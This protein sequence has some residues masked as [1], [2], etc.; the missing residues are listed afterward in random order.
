MP[1]MLAKLV[2]PRTSPPT[3][4]TR[5]QDLPAPGLKSLSR[6]S[7][8]A[9]VLL[10]G[11]PGRWTRAVS[12]GMNRSAG[13]SDAAALARTEGPLESVVLGELQS[14]G[15]W[16]LDEEGEPCEL[17]RA[18]LDG[19]RWRPVVNY[20]GLCLG[21][22]AGLSLD[23]HL[24]STPSGPVL[25]L[26]PTPRNTRALTGDTPRHVP[27]TW[28]D[29]YAHIG[30]PAEARLSPPLDLDVSPE[31]VTWH[32]GEVHLEH[33][34][35]PRIVALL[36]EAREA[37]EPLKSILAEDHGLRLRIAEDLETR[38]YRAR[39]N[40]DLCELFD[41]ARKT[42][43]SRILVDSPDWLRV[44][45][46]PA[47]SEG[48]PG[49]GDDDFDEVMGIVGFDTE[50]RR[51]ACR[52]LYAH[53]PEGLC[54]VVWRKSAVLFPVQLPQWV[55]V[56]WVYEVSREDNASYVFLPESEEVLA[57][58]QRTLSDVGFG[59]ERFLRDEAARAR[60]GFVARVL[61]TGPLDGW[62]GRLCARVARHL[63]QAA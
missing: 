36:E 44:D 32:D 12:L 2:A 17:G 41:L 22:L 39:T 47:G 38:S 5:G 54:P 16:F 8:G 63:R 33:E 40:R 46:L 18:D 61:H 1:W 25:V 20:T 51:A 31:A 30:G 24:L 56:A 13:I 58:V 7:P 35:R 37:Y 60:T 34:G 57:E 15:E 62:W 49:G 52:R 4:R 43:L 59:R 14:Y 53:R 48:N 42:Q 27:P 50:D 23:A 55:R 11:S 21:S 19:A 45:E 28:S 29:P 26:P 9:L 6:L 3:V 10:D